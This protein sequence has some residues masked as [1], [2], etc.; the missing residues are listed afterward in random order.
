MTTCKG[1]RCLAITVG[2][3]WGEGTV[4]RRGLYQSNQREEGRSRLPTVR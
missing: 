4:P 1:C 2:A 3:R